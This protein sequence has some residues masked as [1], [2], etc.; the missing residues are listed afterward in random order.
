MFAEVDVVD[1]NTG[2]AFSLLNQA[3]ST[4][5]FTIEYFSNVWHI[6]A[7]PN[8]AIER[9]AS[10]STVTKGTYKLVGVW[11]STSMKLYL[12][13]SLIASGSNSQSFNINVD[14]LLLGQLRISGDTG[15]RNTVI[16]TDLYNTALTDAEA[17][18]L[19]TI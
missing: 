18:A 19:T 4:N 16:Q 11:E 8:G 6:T 3:I 5:Y 17:I 1:T 10:T 15:T 9:I 12:N 13:G 2:S 14:S 7:R